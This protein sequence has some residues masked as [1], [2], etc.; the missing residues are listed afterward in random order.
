MVN[1]TR[2][3]MQA[4]L[5]PSCTVAT[6]AL[7][8]VARLSSAML[9]LARTS[10]RVHMVEFASSTLA[11]EASRGSG[12]YGGLSSLALDLDLCY[13]ARLLHSYDWIYSRDGLEAALTW[14]WGR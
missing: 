5:S 11:Y 2:K 3:G 9:T 12:V 4:Q 10:R 1:S 13:D 14:S 6:R 7:Y 8:T